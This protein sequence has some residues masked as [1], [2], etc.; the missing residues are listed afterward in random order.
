MVNGNSSSLSISR[1]DLHKVFGIWVR[2]ES[3]SVYMYYKTYHIH[4]S[5][6]LLM[7]HSFDVYKNIRQ[8]SLKDC[9]SMHTKLATVW[10]NPLGHSLGHP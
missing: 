3:M 4:S 5:S 1:S 8:S 7:F 2:F 9:V 10:E 6:L